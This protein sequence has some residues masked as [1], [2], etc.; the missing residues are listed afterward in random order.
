MSYDIYQKTPL[1]TKSRKPPAKVPLVKITL[2]ANPQVK[3]EIKRIAERERLSVSKVG[4]A[5][6]E[7]WVHQQ[8]H[9]QHAVLW[10]TI[11]DSY[12]QAYESLQ[13][14]FSGLV[15]AKPVFC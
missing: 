3:A 2:W 6:L 1:A 12:R 9:L 11:I 15:S 14:A 13:Q 10:E 5:A 8:L 4:A 7:G